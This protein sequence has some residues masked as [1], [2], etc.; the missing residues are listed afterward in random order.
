MSNSQDSKWDDLV[1]VVVQWLQNSPIITMDIS[2]ASWL[3]TDGYNLLKDYQVPIQQTMFDLYD[4]SN[5]SDPNVSE[6]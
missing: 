6:N 2:F 4:S 5:M 3:D 1:E